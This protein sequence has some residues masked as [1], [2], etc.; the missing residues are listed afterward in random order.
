MHSQCKN[1]NQWIYLF[2]IIFDLVF[3]N[4]HNKIWILTLLETIVIFGTAYWQIYYI[5]KILDNRRIVWF[6]IQ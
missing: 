1:I 3:I 6:K 2:K 5:K 4:A